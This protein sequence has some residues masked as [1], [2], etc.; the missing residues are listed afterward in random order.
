[1]DNRYKK[2]SVNENKNSKNQVIYRNNSELA[3]RNSYMIYELNNTFNDKNRD[4]LNDD[5]KLS[6]NKNY[7][8]VENKKNENKNK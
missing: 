1:M 4:V 3:D 8:K 5:G 7:I 6:N 2:N